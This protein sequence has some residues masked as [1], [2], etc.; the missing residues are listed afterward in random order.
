MKNNEI[1]ILKKESGLTPIG[2]GQ[3]LVE[4]TG[5]VSRKPICRG[6]QDEISELST[7]ITKSGKLRV[8]G[9]RFS[10]AVTHGIWWGTFLSW[11]IPSHE[12]LTYLPGATI[13]GMI[14]PTFSWIFVQNV[15]EICHNYVHFLLIFL[16]NLGKYAI[17][18]REI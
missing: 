6:A 11:N 16:V 13:H 18:C 4:E 5:H 3:P 8:E 9:G 2:G 7:Q 1:C 10:Q 14:I 17:A 15:V 12:N